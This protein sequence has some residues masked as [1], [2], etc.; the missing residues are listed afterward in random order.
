MLSLAIACVWVFA[1]PRAARA[2]VPGA[3]LLAPGVGLPAVPAVDV[4]G[5]CRVDR[6]AVHSLVRRSCLV[7]AEEVPR[8]D[9]SAAATMSY[10]LTAV[11]FGISTRSVTNDPLLQ[12]V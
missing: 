7:K 5:M 6:Y 12:T 9:P 8:S 1:G 4:R 2:R 10:S 3:L 11:L